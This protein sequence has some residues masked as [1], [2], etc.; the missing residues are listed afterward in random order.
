MNIKLK[1]ERNVFLNLSHNYN[2]LWTTRIIIIGVVGGGV[3]SGRRVFQIPTT[4]HGDHPRISG[5][6]KNKIIVQIGKSDSR[7]KKRRD[8]FTCE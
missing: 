2:T 4:S 8:K 5:L 7:F 3:G 1:K 6:K